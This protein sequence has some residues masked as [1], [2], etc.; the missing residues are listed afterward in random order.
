MAMFTSEWD[1]FDFA[2]ERDAWEGAAQ[3]VLNQAF[4]GLKHQRDEANADRRE[5][6]HLNHSQ[7][8][9]IAELKASLSSLTDR[10][11]AGRAITGDEAE[12]FRKLAATAV[13]VPGEAGDDPVERLL[14]LPLPENDLGASTVREGLSK[15]LSVAWR[16]GGNWSPTGNSDWQHILYRAM[17]EAGMARIGYGEDGYVTEPETAPSYA[18]ANAAITAAIERPGAS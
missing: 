9:L 11:E 5:L 3:A 7:A 4:P 12:E 14:A 13:P 17:T 2:P 8:C 1:G 18:E 10:A 15:A 6:S 16:D